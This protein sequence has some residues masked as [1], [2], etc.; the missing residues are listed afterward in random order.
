MC[1]AAAIFIAAIPKNLFQKMLP[2]AAL[3]LLFTLS[4]GFLSSCQN[5]AANRYGN[6][7]N[8]PQARVQNNQQ[9]PA[10]YYPNQGYPQAQQYQQP[11]SYYQQQ[12]QQ[13]YYQNAPAAASRYYA[14]PY[15]I[16]AYGNNYAPRYDADQYYVPPTSYQ[17]IE[18]Q[19][20][21][22]RNNGST[23]F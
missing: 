15:D 16:P 20:P 22:F 21:V 7:R 6:S 18:N 3:F 8:A 9:A 2:K 17:N 12:G 4:L 23:P 10:P 13:T 14:N 1:A 5:N 19:K 11:Q